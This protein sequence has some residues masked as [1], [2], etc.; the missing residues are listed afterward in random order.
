[1]TTLV[2]LEVEALHTLRQRE[3]VTGSGTERS[4]NS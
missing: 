1:M 4:M 3:E 2:E